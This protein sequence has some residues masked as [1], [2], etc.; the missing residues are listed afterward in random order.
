MRNRLPL[1]VG[2]V[3]AHRRMPLQAILD[4]GRRMLQQQPLGGQEVWTVVDVAANGLPSNKRWLAGHAA[5]PANSGVHLEQNG[6][7]LTWYVP[8]F[9][10]DGRTCDRW[11]PYTFFHADKDGNQ[12]PDGR[13]RAFKGVRPTANGNEACWLVHAGDL[14]KGDRVYFTPATFDF[15]WLDSASRRFEI[16]YD[17]EGRRFGRRNRPYLLDDLET[18]REA[19]SRIAGADGLTA[20]Q[21]HALREIIESRREMWRG[22]LQEE[23]FQW[24]CRA[25]IRNA[26]WGEK[27]ADHESDQLSGWASSGLLS[28]VI[29]LYMEIMKRNLNVLTCRS[30]T[31]SMSN[32]LYSEERFLLMTLDPVHI[33]T[34][35]QHLGRVDLSIAREPGTRLPKIPA[36]R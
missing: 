25:A 18:I 3:Y 10:G 11:Y 4:A 26:K 12:E 15:E 27:L 33:G 13:A 36:H 34:G 2:V 17:E 32:G 28:D 16:A 7:S 6:R 22:S 24:L 1:H 31:M 8:A 19:W 23:T 5:V 21:I 9:M 35:G 14:Q 20:S 30:E 29:E